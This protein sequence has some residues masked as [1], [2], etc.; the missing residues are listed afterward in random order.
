MGGEGGKAPE[1]RKMAGD[2]TKRRTGVL[3]REVKGARAERANGA[4]Y[5]IACPL[6]RGDALSFIIV[7]RS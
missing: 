3:K 4:I 2:R 1:W 5:R 6:D 7:L